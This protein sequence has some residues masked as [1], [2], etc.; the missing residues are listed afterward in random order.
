MRKKIN[1]LFIT[2]ILSRHQIGLWDYFNLYD[3]VNFCYL[4]TRSSKMSVNSRY[5]TNDDKNYVI[6]SEMLTDEKLKALIQDSDVIFYGSIED[7]R[8]KV[9][10]NGFKNAFIISEHYSKSDYHE[11][12]LFRG[13]RR[14]L[15]FRKSIKRVL[16]PINKKYVFCASGHTGEDFILSGAP[17]TSLLKFGYFPPYRFATEKEIA[18]KD[19]NSIIY[20]GRGVDFKHPEVAIWFY[21]VIS[22]KR[23]YYLNLYGEGVDDFGLNDKN[24]IYH[25]MVPNSELIEELLKSSIFVF[26]SDRREGWGVVLGE[27][28]AAGCICF[29]NFDAGSTRYLIKD[30]INGFLYRNKKELKSKLKKFR[31]MGKDEILQM[32]LNAV[33]YINEYWSGRIASE[34]IHE[35]V[36]TVSENNQFTPYNEG[37]LSL[38]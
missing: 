33:K 31:K 14:R 20:I 17:R 24:I 9:L 15:V 4:C 22:K 6:Y 11:L 7:K 36:L 25:G 18:F 29:A 23:Q 30:G 1:V 2:N 32:R 10:L 8:I 12:F 28:M 19:K 34:R 5:S 16:Q 35:F 21:N 3:D 27:A 38:D 26:S 37:P 13:L